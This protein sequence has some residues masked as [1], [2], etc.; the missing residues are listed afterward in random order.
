MVLPCWM[1][2][3]RFRNLIECRLDPV[4][5]LLSCFVPLGDTFGSFFHPVECPMDG[6]AAF[7]GE[8]QRSDAS[9]PQNRYWQEPLAHNHLY[10]TLYQYSMANVNRNF[11]LW[12][13][14]TLPKSITLRGRHS[15]AAQAI[16]IPGGGL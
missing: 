9:Y 7:I 1:R 3:E 16:G 13:R 8:Q 11:R 14:S 5:F 6:L 12:M 4:Q 15:L 2:F 10:I